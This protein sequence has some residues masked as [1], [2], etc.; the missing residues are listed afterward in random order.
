MVMLN[1]NWCIANSISDY[2]ARSEGVFE[3]VCRIHQ[4]YGE[5]NPLGVM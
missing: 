4:Y 5:C 1:E 2:L 3:N